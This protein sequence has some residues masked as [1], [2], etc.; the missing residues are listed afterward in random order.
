[1]PSNAPAVPCRITPWR[2]SSSHIYS[3][4]SVAQLVPAS[5]FAAPCLRATM[6]AIAPRQR[7]EAS[8]AA[9][10]AS[11]VLRGLS[12]GVQPSSPP[13]WRQRRRRRKRAGGLSTCDRVKVTGCGAPRDSR[14]CSSMSSSRYC[15]TSSSPRSR[16][17]R[18][19]RRA[20]PPR[21]KPR[22]KS[23]PALSCCMSVPAP[24]GLAPAAVLAAFREL[25]R[26]CSRHGDALVARA[27]H[28][29]R[30]ACSAT[31]ATTLALVARA[32]L[33]GAA[34]LCRMSLLLCSCCAVLLLCCAGL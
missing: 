7:A 8:A 13:P 14:S 1:M 32:C 9:A 21:R 15:W 5:C 30:H 6:P 24:P 33:R 28:A 34:R 27:T 16:A 19:K 4:R 11:L 26:R 20:W 12:P 17:K 3:S 22:R 29:T 2:S 31:H 23:V 25:R 10:A 18:R